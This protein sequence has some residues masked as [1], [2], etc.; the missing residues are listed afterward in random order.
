MQA[1]ASG[2]SVGECL[3][4]ARHALRAAGCETAA[5]DAELLLACVL[6]ES[7]LSLIAHP[8]HVLSPQQQE[9]FQCLVSRRALHEPVAYLTGQKEFY[10]LAFRVSQAVLIP[11]PETELLVELAIQ[12]AAHLPRGVRAADV[13][14]G[15]GCIAGSVAR[16]VPELLCDACD[17]SE[18]ALALARENAARHGV[19]ERICFVRSD[20]LLSLVGRCYQIIVS[21]PPYVPSQDIALLEPG[22]RS[23]EPLTA[24][25]GGPDGLAAVH[26]LAAQAAE[27]LTTGGRLLV[28]I[29][30]G[31]GGAMEKIAADAGLALAGVY[32]ALAGIPRVAEMLRL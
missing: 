4:R 16:N 25:D 7:R 32:P 11:R 6:Q 26:R 17:I 20:L 18:A 19:T 22:V 12:R 24:L 27:S 1:C 23:F 15:S 28:E 29:G 21:N 13:G 10:G 5:L 31:Q 8:E 9:T 30:V 2:A 14:T 3:S